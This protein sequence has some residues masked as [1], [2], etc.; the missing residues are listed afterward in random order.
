MT[1]TPCTKPTNAIPGACPGTAAEGRA[2]AVARPITLYSLGD[3]GLIASQVDPRFSY[4]THVPTAYEVGAE[5]IQ[6]FDLIV[7]VHGSNRIVTDYRS[8]FTP[9]AEKLGCFVLAPLFPIGI[10]DRYD[11]DN[12]KYIEYRGIRYD[13]LLLT[14][15]EEAKDYYGVEFKRIVL[16]GFSGGGQ[17][18]HRFFMLHPKVLTAISIGAP[19]KVTLID[20][21]H[22]WWVGT[23]DVEERFS[24]RI[25]IDAMKAVRTMLVIGERDLE[26]DEIFVEPGTRNWMDGAN[27]AGRTRMDRITS[28]HGNFRQHG[29]DSELKIAPGLAH[30]DL[31]IIPVAAEFFES[32]LA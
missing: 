9:L 30:D 26:Q 11:A 28:L 20:N 27:S 31:K 1:E 13:H 19:G 18:A 21:K 2:D 10:I 3:S 8:G 15:I 22:S 24:R 5:H 12:Y 17:F 23:S 32:V 4:A 7:S 6:S 14:M 25:D 16:H 29:I